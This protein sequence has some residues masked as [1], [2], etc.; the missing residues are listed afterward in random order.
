MSDLEPHM[1]FGS[2][3]FFGDPYPYYRVLQEARPV[4][5]NA[6][7]QSWL[8]TRY[9]DVQEGLSRTELSSKRSRIDSMEPKEREQLVGLHQFY[10]SWLMFSDP[11]EHIEAKRFL[12]KAM[13]DELIVSAGEALKHEAARLIRQVNEH[14][15]MDI[16]EEYAS[17]LT[18]PVL[19]RLVGVGSQDCGMIEGWSEP[20]VSFL[21]KRRPVLSDGL[22]AQESAQELLGYLDGLVSKADELP[23]YSL[24]STLAAQDLSRNDA[25]RQVLLAAIANVLIDGH[26]PVVAA[27]SNSI[28]ALASQGILARAPFDGIE[29]TEEAL[30][31]LLRYDPPFQ[32]AA[33]IAKS[34]WS[35]GSN[36]IRDG[37]RVMFM[38]GAANR[39]LRTFADPHQLQLQRSPNR[40]LS[41]GYGSHYCLGAKVARVIL[42]ELFSQLFKGVP[43]FSMDLE[44]AVWKRSVGY[45]QVEHLDIS[46]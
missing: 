25:K 16:V 4:Y 44:R 38:L 33:R 12:T 46:W 6:E 3:E 21:G 28:L 2:D 31:E 19:C 15:R 29:I 34:G 13:S 43:R 30:E 40:H 1:L 8:I 5:W 10:S 42:R 45:R 14:K 7:L 24:L 22:D 27:F 37:E 36:R 32:Y 17:R 23:K 20:I 9:A 26:A 11:P 41:F 18:V 35:L 39:D